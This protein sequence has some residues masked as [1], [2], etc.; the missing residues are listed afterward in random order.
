MFKRS[1]LYSNNGN[2][3]SLDRYIE[4]IDGISDIANSQLLYYLDQ[5]VEFEEYTITRFECRF[6]LI[7]E[8]IYGHQKYDW[9]LQYINRIRVEDLIRGRKIKYI[10][11]AR[12]TQIIQL[13]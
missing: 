8:D 5:E 13:I 9:I 12:L 4:V 11:L 3:V 1:K 10:P 7:S 6:D 2:N